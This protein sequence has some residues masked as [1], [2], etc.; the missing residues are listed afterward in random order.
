[1]CF[2]LLV[3]PVNFVQIFNR[4]TTGLLFSQ[5]ARFSGYVS[6]HSAY[7]HGEASLASTIIGMAQNSVESN[8]INLLS[9]QGQFGTPEQGGKNHASP[10]CLFACLSPITRALFPQ[11]DD[12]L[13]D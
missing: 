6:E 3:I 10:R 11:G 5:V 13:Q 4:H 8:N 2:V 12:V 7:H 1:M 9:R